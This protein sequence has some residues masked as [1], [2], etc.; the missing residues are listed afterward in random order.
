MAIAAQDIQ[1]IFFDFS[2]VLAEEG[3]VQGLKEI[4]RRNGQDPETFL[5]T[6]AD[7]CYA[8]GYASGRAD[9]HAFWND[10]RAD[11]GVTGTDEELRREIL[12]RFIIRPWML[13]A[14]AQV[15]R[16]NLRTAILSDHTNWLEELDAV[17]GIF[18]HFDRVFNSFREGMTKR[19]ADF[20][21][22]AC[23]VMSVQP[24]HALFID[25][26]PSNTDRAATVG[27]NTI[28]YTTYAEFVTR[29]R[30]FVPGIVLPPEG[31]V[32]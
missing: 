1:V 15:R 12:S 4:G 27:L 32:S 3:F 31:S 2:G 19:S 17:H 22:H 20:F 5:R 16:S 10:V 24:H 28:T 18:R 26:N 13:R 29:M 14:A 11:T 21:T 8:N 6:A 7:I 9:E 25:D 23:A 30:G